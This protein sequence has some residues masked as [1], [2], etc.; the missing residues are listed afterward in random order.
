MR[1]Y[2]QMLIEANQNAEPN[3]GVTLGALCIDKRYPVTK[4][5]E[6]LKMSRQGVYDWFTGKSKPAKNKEDLIQKVINEIN[7]L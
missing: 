3:I 7:A 2:S 4:V 1:G 6:R 5:A